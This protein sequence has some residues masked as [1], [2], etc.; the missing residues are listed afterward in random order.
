[1]DLLVHGSLNGST[2]KEYRIKWRAWAAERAKVNLGPWVY[3]EDG[4]DSAARE[5]TVLMASRGLSYKIHRQTIKGYLT[6][7]KYF[8][9]LQAGWE[10]PISH[11][12][13]CISGLGKTI[14]KVHARSDTKPDVR[15][16]LTVAMLLAGRESAQ[17]RGN[18]QTSDGDGD[19]FVIFLAVSCV[20]TVG[21]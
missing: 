17:N 12:R 6:T 9:K 19:Y 11:F 13:L 20:R 3:E 5:L 2:L 16:P 1:M 7:I 10:L 4:V 8:H 21:V 14:D 18:V 15:N